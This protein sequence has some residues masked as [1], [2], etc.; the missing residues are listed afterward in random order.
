MKVIKVQWKCW[1]DQICDSC[2]AGRLCGD[3][4][5]NLIENLWKGLKKNGANLQQFEEHKGA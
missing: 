3:I 5:Q 2:F 1:C 4:S